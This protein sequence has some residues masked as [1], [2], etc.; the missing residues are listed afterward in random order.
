MR[1]TTDFRDKSAIANA[2]TAYRH[3]RISRRTMLQ[4]LAAA[5]V[6]LSAT[7]ARP[8]RAAA[9]ASPTAE[10]A[11]QPEEIV[12]W[13]EDVGRQFEGASIKVVSEE[14]P[15][16]RA[17]IN[18]KQQ[19]F[20]ELTGIT[21]DW[22]V[23]PL[24]QVLAKVSQDAASQLGANDIYY[25][26]QAWV[27]RFINDTFDPRELLEQKPD[28]AMPNYDIDDF[29]QPLVQHI[30]TYGDKM[31]GFPCDVPIFMYFYRSDI[32]DEMG[33]SPATTMEEYLANAKAINDAMAADGTYGTVGQMQ[34]GHYALN[35]DMT[36]WVWSHGGSVFTADGMCSL[37]D[38]AAVTGVDYMR[39]L[40][41]YMPAAVTTYDWGGQATAIQQG[42][43]GQVITWGEDF[44]GWDDPASSTVSGLM[45]P[46]ALPANAAQRPAEEAGF[47]EVPDLGHQGGSTYCLSRYSKNADPAWVFLQWATSSNTQ[48]LASIIG[49]G[50]SPMRQST[51]DDPRVQANAQVGI[52]GTTRHFPAMYDVI[53][54]R[55]GTEPHL[56]QWPLIATDIIAVELGKLTTG[57]YGSTQ[58]GMDTIKRLVDEAAAR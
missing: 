58:E 27:G 55:M 33:L 24:A 36:A 34:S 15:P 47:E 42:Q 25:F 46:V 30:A 56:P 8:R 54:N 11:D 48:T 29:L 5:G 23:V 39:E 3:G 1:E 17:I 57:G 22:E 37:N 32:Y 19:Y 38:A 16:S 51:F 6:A 52:A 28:L 10:V 2:L 41:T 9:Q 7:P 20:E 4:T 45:E 13:L 35:C 49:G 26:D 21:V 43:G 50:A 53:M 44:P 18:L 12:A 40:Q 14:T 31:I